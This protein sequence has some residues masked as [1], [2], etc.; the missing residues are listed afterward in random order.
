MSD[1]AEKNP[2]VALREIATKNIADKLAERLC[3]MILEG[4]LPSGYVF[5]SEN[6]LSE[7]LQVGRST[8]REAYNVLKTRGLITRTKRGTFVNHE[9]DII[10]N[11]PFEDLA[12]RSE[13]KEYFEFFKIIFVQSAVW[14]SERAA[15]DDIEILFESLEKLRAA[16]IFVEEFLPLLSTFHL[17][18]AD[19]ANNTLLRKSMII[20][21]E[22]F[23]KKMSQIGNMEKKEMWQIINSHERIADSIEQKDAEQARDSAYNALKGLYKYLD[24]C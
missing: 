9:E 15:D 23:I 18:I 6:A 17:R 22:P 5:P 19:A 2:L 7:E 24:S 8:I 11:M 21:S 16:N 1:G 10:A 20:L 14:A 12:E 4:K 13:Q 3:E